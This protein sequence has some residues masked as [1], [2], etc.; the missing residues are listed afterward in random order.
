[1]IYTIGP[2][3]NLLALVIHCSWFGSILQIDNSYLL[4]S[5]QTVVSQCY[6][7]V[8][9][10][11]YAWPWCM[12][13]TIYS[14]NKSYLMHDQLVTYSRNYKWSLCATLNFVNC[15]I[16]NF[17]FFLYI[18]HDCQLSGS[19][20]LYS[21]AQTIRS[22]FLDDVGQLQDTCKLTKLSFMNSVRNS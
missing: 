2:I 19:Y 7:I 17:Y 13:S 11:T 1:M 10:E 15:T 3:V 6:N 12:I 4:Y 9:I 5:I 18:K 22:Q 20:N 14:Y 8:E 21:I 16:A